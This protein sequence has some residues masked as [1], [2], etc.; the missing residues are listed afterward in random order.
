MRRSMRRPYPV[1]RINAY[2]PVTKQPFSQMNTTP[3]IDVL[4]VLLIMIIMSIPLATHSV[5]VD[6][7]A[8]GPGAASDPQV[9]LTIS[10]GGT[11]GWNGETITRTQLQQRLGETALLANQPVIRFQPAAQASYDDSVQ[12]INLVADAR[13]EKFAFSGN[14]QHR[15]FGRD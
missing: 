1:H 13:L 9:M 12:V 4:L 14:E 10:P 6:L 2:A 7:P 3:L 8:P 11:I 15:T 5:E